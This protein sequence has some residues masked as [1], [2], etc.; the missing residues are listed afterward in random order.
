MKDISV[1]I[2]TY[3]HEKYIRHALDSVLM[4]KTQYNYKVYVFED[5]SQ[6]STADILR[7]Y[8]EKY[9]NKINCFFNSENLGMIENGKKLW[10]YLRKDPADY[11]AV[12]D[13]DDYWIDAYKLEKQ[14]SFL[15]AN[16]K[17]VA[18]VHNVQVVDGNEEEIVKSGKYPIEEAHDVSLKD[19]LRCLNIGQ[20]S[21]RVYKN[22]F[23][24]MSEKVF[25]AFI[26]GGNV[27]DC[28]VIL[29]LASL[30]EIY[31]MKDVMSAYRYQ[32]TGDSWNARQV[33]TNPYIRNY[34]M[35]EDFQGFGR[36]AFGIEYDYD[37][38]KNII[39]GISLLNCVKNFNFQNLKVFFYLFF[40]KEN[41]ISTI[42]YIFIMGIKYIFCGINGSRDIPII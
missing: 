19:V 30:G 8:S 7:E 22:V 24:D 3:N 9:P 34:Q 10:R 2:I 18:T 27:G 4:Q 31:Y 17:Y 5:C 15:E 28:K 38:R 16:D 12:L 21:S 36:E 35:C 20:S 11:I 32:L 14:V 1:Y 29:L 6:D 23:R 25:N 26:D 33:G 40:K 41:K 42:K 13:G 39:V 37:Y